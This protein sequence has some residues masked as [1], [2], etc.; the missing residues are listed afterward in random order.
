MNCPNCNAPLDPGQ[1]F[2]GSCGQPVVQPKRKDNI[3]VNRTI[4]ADPYDY[5]PA[6]PEQNYPQPEPPEQPEQSYSEQY[7]PEQNYQQPYQ[8]E[9][10]YRQPYQPEQNYR[11]PYQP[12][13]NYQQ[14]Y[15]PE[16]SYQQQYQ[17]EQNYQQQYQPNSSYSS[18]GNDRYAEQYNQYQ[19]PSQYGNT[20]G[21][22]SYTTNG[23]VMVRNNNK[24]KMIIIIIV[25]AVVLIGGTLGT[26]LGAVSCANK[27]HRLV[28][29]SGTFIVKDKAINVNDSDAESKINKFFSERSISMHQTSSE[30]EYSI[31]V[32]GNTILTI[33]K[34]SSGATEEDFQSAKRT[35]TETKTDMKSERETVGVNN[36]VEVFALMRNNGSVYYVKVAS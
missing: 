9:Q 19:Q 16:Q 32:H 11:Q 29:N 34:L 4:A 22:Y 17:P 33:L 5:A 6:A 15:Q 18:G 2:C 26:V 13:Q 30:G 27:K 28:S 35:M 36:L 1:R 25:A 3:D 10:N 23:G 24:T 12:E 8:P 14:Q 21:A 20:G 31:E 7:Q